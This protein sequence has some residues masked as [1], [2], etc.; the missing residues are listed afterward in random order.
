M[1]YAKSQANPDKYHAFHD[2]RMAS[3]C[4]RAFALPAE[5]LD[6]IPDG[7]TLCGSCHL[8]ITTRKKERIRYA[9]AD[10]LD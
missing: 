1:K 6:A 10:R 7:A 3:I 5:Q 9:V 2:D 8:Y 4:G